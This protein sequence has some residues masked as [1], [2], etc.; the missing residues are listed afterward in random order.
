LSGATSGLS[1]TAGSD[2]LNFTIP[3]G[4]SLS[5]DLSGM[6]QLASGYN[7][8]TANVNGNAPSSV[9]GVTVGTDGT[10]SFQYANGQTVSAY[11]IP[12]VNVSSPDNLQ[13]VSGNAY[14]VNLNSGPMQIGTAGQAGYGAIQSS[15]LESSTVD[16]ASELTAM[17]NAQS[18]YQAN[19]KSFQTGA[20]LLDILNNLKT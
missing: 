3:N 6:T 13:A 5:L 18:A 10:L 11:Q 7:V 17:V 14:Q 1:F 19:S 12:L 2:K 8:N 20:T 15:S 4:Q 9:T 16:L